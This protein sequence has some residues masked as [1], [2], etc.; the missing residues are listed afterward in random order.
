[1]SPKSN[2]WCS[3]MKRGHRETYKEDGHEKREADIG[4]T[5]LPA[6]E[7][8]GPLETGGGKGGFFPR[9]FRG[10]VD[11]DLELLGL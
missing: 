4:V 8:L 10:P 1:M 2:D 9:A 3:Y 11:L 5:L 6:K 7:C